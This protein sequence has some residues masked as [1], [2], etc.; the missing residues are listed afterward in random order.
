MRFFSLS[1]SDN[2]LLKTTDFCVL[3]LYP[4]ILLHLFH[5]Q[6]LSIVCHLIWALF[7]APQSSYNHS[8]KDQQT[9][10][11]KKKKTWNKV[12]IKKVWKR[13]KKKTKTVKKIK[14][15]W[16]IARIT[17]TWHRDIKWANAVG[18]M[19]PTDLFDPGLP[20]NFIF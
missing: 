10:G 15:A 5:T 6:H 17:K 13:E 14:K 7:M 16:N 19:V 8:I 4:T 11:I 1:L 2:S 12:K 3:I 18:K 20:Q 9:H